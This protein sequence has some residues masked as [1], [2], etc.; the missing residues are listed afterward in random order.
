MINE[1]IVEL[2]NRGYKAKAETIIKNGIEKTGILVGEDNIRPV[3]YPNTTLT[4]N[5]CVKEIINIYNSNATKANIDITKVT[6]WEYAKN[7]LQLCLQRKTNEDILK[8]KYL[9]MEMYVR[10]RVSENSTYKIKSGVFN[11][12]EDEIFARAILNMKKDILVEDMVEIMAEMMGCDISEISDPN[13]QMIVITNKAKLNGAVAICDKEL[14]STI[15]KKYNSNL[16][17]IPSSIHEC[18]I[19]INNNPD[20]ELYSNMVREVNETIEPE[21]ILSDHAYFFNKETCEITW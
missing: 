16:L 13:S 7:N 1:I 5:E 20:M 15:A 12:S 2:N 4:V 3:F 21:E 6:S 19:Y 9:D 11:V 17:I 14:L 8:R 10:V 18:I